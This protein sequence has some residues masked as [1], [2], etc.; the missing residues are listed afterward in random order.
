MTKTIG[1]ICGSLRENSYNRIVAQSLTDM[2]E[3]AQFCWIELSNL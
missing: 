1:L 2:D 3:S